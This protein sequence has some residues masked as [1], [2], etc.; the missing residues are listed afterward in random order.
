MRDDVDYYDGCIGHEVI[1]V[2]YRRF[3][4]YTGFLGIDMQQYEIAESDIHGNDELVKTCGSRI[5]H[6]S[7]LR[8]TPIAVF[9][10]ILTHEELC[11]HLVGQRVNFPCAIQF[12]FNGDDKVCVFRVEIDFVVGLSATL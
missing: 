7:L 9:P 2:Q 5:I 6:T 3:S 12:I 1:M 4:E 10:H 8:K 11:S